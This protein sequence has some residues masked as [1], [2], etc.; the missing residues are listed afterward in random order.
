M[1][2]VAIDAAMKGLVTFVVFAFVFVAAVDGS[3]VFMFFYCCFW[4][5]WCMCIVVVV[6]LS[7][8]AVECASVAALPEHDAGR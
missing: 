1:A 5:W 4:R 8:C 6:V 3:D 2:V 7:E